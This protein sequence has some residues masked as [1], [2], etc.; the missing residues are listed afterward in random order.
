MLKILLYVALVQPITGIRLPHK[1]A[2]RRVFKRKPRL[3]YR[4][5]LLNRI[6]RMPAHEPFDLNHAY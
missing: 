2:I 5:R 4:Q 3:T 1:L 6:A